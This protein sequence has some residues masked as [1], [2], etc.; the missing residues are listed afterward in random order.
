MG[1]VLHF[2]VVPESASSRRMGKTPGRTSSSSESIL[3][4]SLINQEFHHLVKVRICWASSWARR[5][6]RT[7][8]T[9]RAS[10][11][12]GRDSSMCATRATAPTGVMRR[13]R[14]ADQVLSEQRAAQ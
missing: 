6:S 9:P 11:G 12:I 14:P 3:R 13:R 2:V 10:V 4:P 1:F 8:D 7:R 5:S